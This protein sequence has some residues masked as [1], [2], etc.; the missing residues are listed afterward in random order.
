MKLHIHLVRHFEDYF[1]GM[2]D[3]RCWSC[4]GLIQGIKAVGRAF[5]IIPCEHRIR[6]AEEMQG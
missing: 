1:R 3:G 4:G 2:P 5:Y 6:N